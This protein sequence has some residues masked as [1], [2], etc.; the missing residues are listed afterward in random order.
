M[1][2]RRIQS[3]NDLKELVE[4]GSTRKPT[5]ANQWKTFV[6]CQEMGVSISAQAA[7]FGMAYG[8]QANRV[9]KYRFFL[10]RGD[11]VDSDKTH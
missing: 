2:H 5:A 7:L 4:A 8:T 11:E 3:M 9:N 10:L 1:K 6:T